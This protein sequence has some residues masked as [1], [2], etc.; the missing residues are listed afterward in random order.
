MAE[1]MRTR[2]P[3]STSSD[4]GDRI[5]AGRS[6]I[7]GH[8]EKTPSACGQDLVGFGG[9]GYDRALQPEWRDSADVALGAIVDGTTWN[10]G[11]YCRA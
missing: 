8:G 11:F 9:G 6:R 7:A 4:L 10:S 1:A 5:F 2:G 3:L